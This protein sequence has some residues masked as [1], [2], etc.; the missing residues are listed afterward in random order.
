M[1]RYTL[2][3]S[4]SDDII[5]MVLGDVF[6]TTF[7]HLAAVSNDVIVPEKEIIGMTS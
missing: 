5:D 3:S 4:I 2:D 6:D 1:Y 7:I